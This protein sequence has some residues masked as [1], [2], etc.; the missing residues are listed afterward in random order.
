MDANQDQGASLA[1]EPM[2]AS[3][4]G[5]QAPHASCEESIAGA[6]GRHELRMTSAD[7]FVASAMKEYQEG[8]VDPTLWAR[9]A[10]Q[11]GNDESLAIAAYL[12]ARAT[13]VQLQRRD[14][15]RARR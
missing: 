13:A 9:A 15:R 8:H 14:R 1:L 5:D 10:A 4:A 7:E 2:D 11:S 12:S 6:P 3:T